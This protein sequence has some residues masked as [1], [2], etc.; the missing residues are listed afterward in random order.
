MATKTIYEYYC[1]RCGTKSEA[2]SK[3]LAETGRD[4]DPA[5]GASQPAGIKFEL[6]RKCLCNI[7]QN[8]V[9][10]LASFE[11]VEKWVKTLNL[12]NQESY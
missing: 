2:L 4:L 5:G 8:Y 7:V 12:K 11:A 6:C 9:D 3:I 10:S 1:D